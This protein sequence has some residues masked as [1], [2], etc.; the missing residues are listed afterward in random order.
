M[1]HPYLWPQNRPKHSDAIVAPID[2]AKAN[3]E[4]LA[5]WKALLLIE[6]ISERFCVRPRMAVS[7]SL[8]VQLQ[9]VRRAGD[10]RVVVAN[11]L[12]AL[13]SQLVFGKL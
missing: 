10:T 4:D 11:R 5:V 12:L 3:A 9:E 7:V 13:P 2:V 8:H 1:H 6:V